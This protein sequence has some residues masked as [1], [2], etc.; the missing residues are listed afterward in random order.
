[1]CTF[2]CEMLHRTHSFVWYRII[3]GRFFIRYKILCLL[4]RVMV[5]LLWPLE[6]PVVWIALAIQRMPL[7][8]PMALENMANCV[9]VFV[10][11]L[12]NVLGR[13]E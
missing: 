7:A 10:G 12:V 5:A 6:V 1:M 8:Y 2:V 11:K 3:L 9:W 4:N 13:T